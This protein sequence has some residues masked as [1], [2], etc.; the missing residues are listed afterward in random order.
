MHGKDQTVFEKCE[1]SNYP[2]LFLPSLPCIQF[3]SKDFLHSKSWILAKK[4]VPHSVPEVQGF[5]SWNSYF[6]LTHT[7]LAV[8]EFA[9]HFC[10]L[11]IFHAKLFSIF[12]IS[13]SAMLGVLVRSIRFSSS[14]FHKLHINYSCGFLLWA[15][16]HNTRTNG[17]HYNTHKHVY[18]AKRYR[19]QFHINTCIMDH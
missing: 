15:L 17:Y 13:I 2:S 19:K 1:I 6:Q 11:H 4:I 14:F 18:A 5:L 9:K 7:R 8:V 10:V 16:L 12:V 3:R